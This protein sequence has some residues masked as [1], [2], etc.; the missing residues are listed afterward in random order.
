MKTRI[1]FLCFVI[2]LMPLLLML[3]GCKSVAPVVTTPRNDS[4]VIRNVYHHDSIYVQD[5]MAISTLRDTVYIH[6]WHTDLRYSIKNHT[7]TVYLDKE[8]VITMPPEKYVPS[9]YKWCTGSFIVIVVLLLLYVA[10]RIVIR[11]YAHR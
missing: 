8:V 2:L 5:S 1:Y 4:I 9:F 6:K 3:T 10:L 11:I 7:D